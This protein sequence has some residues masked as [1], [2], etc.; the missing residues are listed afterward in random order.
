MILVHKAKA[1][2]EIFA[3]SPPPGYGL[4]DRAV[5]GYCRL[6]VFLGGAWSGTMYDGEGSRYDNGNGNDKGVD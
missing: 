1:R 3:I 5:R 2:S 4:K 6:R